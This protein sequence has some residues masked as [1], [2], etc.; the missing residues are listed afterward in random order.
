MEY[1]GRKSVSL[2]LLTHFIQPEV[3]WHRAF[4]EHASQIFP[5]F[6]PIT[7]F[8]SHWNVYII[9]IH[10]AVIPFALLGNEMFNKLHGL[11]FLASRYALLSDYD[12]LS[13]LYPSNLIYRLDF[14]PVL[15]VRVLSLGR[16]VIV[17]CSWVRHFLGVPLSTHMYKW[18]PA[19]LILGVALRWTSFPTRRESKST[20]FLPVASC[21][22]NREKLCPGSYA[23]LT[24]FTLPNEL[25]RQ[26]TR[27]HIRRRMEIENWKSVD[28]KR[29]EHQPCGQ[30]RKQTYSQSLL[31]RE[32]RSAWRENTNRCRVSQKLFSCSFGRSTFNFG[33]YCQVCCGGNSCF[34]INTA[35]MVD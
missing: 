19:N 9:Q 20:L 28:I 16:E 5:P 12:L 11:C 26:E 31:G 35:C 27:S 23:D 33:F 8:R 17:P 2:P 30:I 34:R 18:V 32:S 10:N 14:K 24:S 15:A 1:S 7:S 21:N 13:L 29:P 6:Q 4:W 3:R 25:K 22:W